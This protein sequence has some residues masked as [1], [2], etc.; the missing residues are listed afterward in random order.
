VEVREDVLVYASEPV[1]EPI[2]ITGPVELR[3]FASSSAPDTDF[4]AKLVNVRPDGYAQNIAEG[5]LRVRFRD[6]SARP[7]LTTPGEILDLTIPRGRIPTWATCWGSTRWWLR[8][9]RR[10]A[11]NSSACGDLSDRS[12]FLY[13]I[14]TNLH[15]RMGT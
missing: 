2:E 1:D 4:T 11:A 6:P 5:I 7:S 3:L 15:A 14:Y 12:N 10:P 13:L 8:S 9:P